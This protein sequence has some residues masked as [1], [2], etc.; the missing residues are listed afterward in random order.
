MTDTITITIDSED[1][2]SKTVD[3]QFSRRLRALADHLEKPAFA[4][5][6]GDNIVDIDGDKIGEWQITP[7]D[8]AGEEVTPETIE[9]REIHADGSH[10]G[11]HTIACP[12][13]RADGYTSDEQHCPTCSCELLTGR[14]DAT[15]AKQPTEDEIQDFNAFIQTH[16]PEYIGSPI[17]DRIMD[18]LDAVRGE[19]TPAEVATL[20]VVSVEAQHTG[21]G[22]IATLH[23]LSDGRI[24]IGSN[25]DE[26]YQMADDLEAWDQSTYINSTVY[27][28]LPDALIQ[29]NLVR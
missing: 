5:S 21:G 14:P 11:D 9:L 13:C 16:L 20:H 25:T 6:Y 3:S 23:T 18:M 2:S 27:R 22:V 12:D 7:A 8:G 19:G 17:E 24:L 29:L 26:S 1:R 10:A 15:P 28:D 4:D